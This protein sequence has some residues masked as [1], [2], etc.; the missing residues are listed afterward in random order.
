MVTS[1]PPKNDDCQLRHPIRR[2]LL[3]FLA[4]GILCIATT[5]F[6]EVGQRREYLSYGIAYSFLISAF[7]VGIGLTP[8]VVQRAIFYGFAGTCIVGILGTVLV[9]RFNPE[10]LML[11]GLIR[12]VHGSLLVLVVTGGMLSLYGW[13]KFFQ[14]WKRGM[15]Q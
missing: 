4:L 5:P 12:V 8:R 6:M 15:A 2:C 3:L 1:R 10:L 14:K 9:I 7:A 11:T 13:F